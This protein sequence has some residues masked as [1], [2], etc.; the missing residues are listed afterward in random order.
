MTHLEDAHKAAGSDLASPSV[1]VRDRINLVADVTARLSKRAEL[2]ALALEIIRGIREADSA[3]PSALYGEAGTALDC[4]AGGGNATTSFNCGV[5]T[6]PLTPFSCATTYNCGTTGTFSCVKG[7]YTC[8]GAKGGTAF[9]CTSSSQV[10]DC[11]TFSCN[12]AGGSGGYNCNSTFDYICSSTYR[13]TT[14]FNCTG[15]HIFLCGASYGCNQTFG[16]SA[17]GQQCNPTYPYTI[18]PSPGDFQCGFGTSG[19]VFNCSSGT[20]TCAAAD[21]F[22]CTAAATFRCGNAAN[23]GS[24]NCSPTGTGGGVQQFNCAT[25]YKCLGSYGCPTLYNCVSSYNACLPPDN[26]YSGC[27]KP[28]TYTGPPTS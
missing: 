13:C 9:T 3:L 7:D 20:F 26:K 12:T 17:G 16:C 4:L 14:S 24:F 25:S 22:G 21:E 11:Y 28:A 5:F 27:W 6:C 15:G 1:A 18:G 10:F 8:G 23:S 19:S 2:M